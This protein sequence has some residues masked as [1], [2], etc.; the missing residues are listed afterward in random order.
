MG[1]RDSALVFKF[2]VV[3]FREEQMVWKGT[4]HV[5]RLSQAAKQAV[6]AVTY[7]QSV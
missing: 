7:Q 1:I 2:V 4:K 6:L 3:N 5:C